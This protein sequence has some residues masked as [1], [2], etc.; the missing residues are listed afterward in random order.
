M[1]CGYRAWV[2]IG[3]FN[4]LIDQNEKITNHCSGRRLSI[5]S[6]LRATAKALSDWNRNVFGFSESR[7][8]NLEAHIYNLQGIEPTD[9]IIRKENELQR[10]LNEWMERSE[11]ILRQKLRELWLSAGDR[12]SKF[13]HASTIANRNYIFIADLKDDDGQWLD[14]RDSIGRY[15][16]TQFFR[17][18][19]SK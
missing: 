17:F 6:K 15:L 3:D 5:V 12:N 1:N 16:Y 4:D 18:V 9:D 2:C 14:S 10:D 13:F 19:Q 7:I 8:K 11:N